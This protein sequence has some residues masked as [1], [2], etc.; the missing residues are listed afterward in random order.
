[1][2]AQ[3]ALGARVQGRGH[4][5]RQP[6]PGPRLGARRA[7]SA[8]RLPT[9]GGA[10]EDLLRPSRTRRPARTAVG[11]TPRPRSRRP[12]AGERGL[13]VP[14]RR[15]GRSHRLRVVQPQRPGTRPL[16]PRGRGRSSSTPAIRT[17][18][19]TPSPSSRHVR[20]EVGGTVVADTRRPVLLFET[21]LP[22][23]VLHPA[24]GRPPRPVRPQRP[25]H[26]VPLRGHRRVLVVAGWRQRREP[27]LEL[28]EAAA[29]GGRRQRPPRLLQRGGRH[30]RGRGTPTSG[31]SPRS[32]RHSR[33]NPRRDGGAGCH[34]ASTK[35]LVYVLDRSTL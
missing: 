13:D 28:P 31:P 12:T 23:A 35:S 29:R 1:M 11:V 8:V 17:S 7:R 18:G 27:R 32:P 24:G 5:R 19:W 6:A 16:I 3:R 26:G 22:D 15:P 4:G 21:G 20:V 30:H 34:L 10:G 9:R 14:R 33:R 2:G 25:Q